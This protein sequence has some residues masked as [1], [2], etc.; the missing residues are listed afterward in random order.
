[1]KIAP[2]LGIIAGSGD[3]PLRLVEVCQSTDRKFFVLALEGQGEWKRFPK[4]FVTKIRFG[5]FGLGIKLLQENLVK[6]LVFAGKVCRPSLSELRPDS[7]GARFLSRLGRSWV[8]DDSL[9]TAIIKE[10]EAEGFRVVGSQ[11]ILKGYLATEGIYGTVKPGVDGIADAKR[12]FELLQKLG[13]EDIGQAAIVQ[14]GNVLGIEAAEGTDELIRRCKTL[15]KIGAGGVLI[16]SPKTGQE[17]R[18][19]LPTIGET[20]V[21]LAN[22]CGLS[23]IAVEAGGVFVI[24]LQRMIELAD[25]NGIFIIGIQPSSF[26][27]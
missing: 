24:E 18:I 17:F 13:V 23:G 4:N 15:Q 11:E 22:E 8:G 21:K 26:R 14:Q 7:R 27:K 9:L 20:T 25:A 6:E 19:D 2:K 16:K 5:D 3:L 1:M 10:F 12:G